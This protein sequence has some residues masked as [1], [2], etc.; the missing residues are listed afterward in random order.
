MATCASC[1]SE[2]T[3]LYCNSCGT[4][5]SEERAPKKTR[6]PAPPKPVSRTPGLLSPQRIWRTVAVAVLALVVYGSGVITG[7]FMAQGSTAAGL[8]GTTPA[9]ATG[10]PGLDAM[11]PLARANFYME[12]GV[13]LMNEG[14]RS[15][16][17]SEFRKS[18]KDWEAA[19]Q[20][21]PDNLY[22]RTYE[23][24]TYYYAGDSKVALE[25][26]RAV[27]E[28]DPN[29][30]WAIFN[31]AW[32]YETAGKKTEATLMYKKY[33]A[34]ADEEKKNQLKYAEQ[35]ELID[36]QVEAATKALEKLGGGGS[37]Q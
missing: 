4:R 13:A 22:A 3:G 35:F 11:P 1:G 9:A 10:D 16:A 19:I 14:Q 6:S 8:G 25:K 5:A 24:L 7:I 15:A 36:R 37:G 2:L 12:K 20:A 27:L 30:L 29:Y 17:V 31:L 18:L 32:I 21:E 26:L 23:G 28:K 34:V 33:V